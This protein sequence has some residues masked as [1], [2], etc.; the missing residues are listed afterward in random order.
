MKDIQLPPIK[1]NGLEGKKKKNYYNANELKNMFKPAISN[2]AVNG[3]KSW[4]APVIGPAN[5]IATLKKISDHKK[6]YVSPYSKKAI[7]GPKPGV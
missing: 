3:K 5:K 6:N 7:L 2:N 1:P 4:V